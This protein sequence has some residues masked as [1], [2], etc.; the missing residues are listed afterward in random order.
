MAKLKTGG[1]NT[2]AVEVSG[3]S[4]HGFWLFLAGRE[5]FVPFKEFPWFEDAPVRKIMNVHRQTKDHLYWPELDIDLSVES[6]EHPERF[7]LRF[8]PSSSNAG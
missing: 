4:K 5:L 2:T 3:I 1:V 7:P 6:I 8:N